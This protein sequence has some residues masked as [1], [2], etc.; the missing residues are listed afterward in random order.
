[1]VARANLDY[2][3]H[4]VA[5]LLVAPT[6]DI[7]YKLYA[8]IAPSHGISFVPF[9]AVSLAAR[10]SRFILLSAFVA[11]VSLGLSRWLSYRQR[12]AI[13][14]ICW[15]IFYSVYFYHNK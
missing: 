5:A 3:D 2:R 8:V 6:R 4:G 1:M 15:A 13:L 9:L 10:L 14:V 11:I 12:F 7:P